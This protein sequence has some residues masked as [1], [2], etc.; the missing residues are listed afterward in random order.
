MYTKTTVQ[1]G[2][3]IT[4]TWANH[5]QT[6]YDEAVAAAAAAVLQTA[7]PQCQVKKTTTQSI[8]S[9]STATL[10]WNT[11]VFDTS[12]M[13]DNVTNN[14]RITIPATAGLYRVSAQLSLTSSGAALCMINIRKNDTTII[15]QGGCNAIMNYVGA[16][17]NVSGLVQCVAGDYLTVEITNNDGEGADEIVVGT[18]SI[19]EAVR[20]GASA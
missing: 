10:T 20:L 9:A 7:P 1:T 13:H 14:S 8:S 3:V 18:A 17:G 2:D 6:Q 16:A 19:F 4:A 15:A 12:V 11:E 5:I